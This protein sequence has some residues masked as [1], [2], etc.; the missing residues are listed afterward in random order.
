MHFP[1]PE[2]AI[3]ENQQFNIVPESIAVRQRPY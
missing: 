1:A 2:E 3:L